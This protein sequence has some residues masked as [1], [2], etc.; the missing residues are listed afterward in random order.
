MARG[1]SIYWYVR[2]HDI[3]AGATA[4]GYT[5]EAT[6][7]I[8][9]VKG[10]EIEADNSESPNAAVTDRDVEIAAERPREGVNWELLQGCWRLKLD[11]SPSAGSEHTGAFGVWRI[12]RVAILP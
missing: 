1:R 11:F 4:R 7:E 8:Q 6:A 2:Q 9:E 10:D 3:Q 5:E 12:G